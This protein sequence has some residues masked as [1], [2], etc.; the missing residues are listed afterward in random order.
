MKKYNVKVSEKAGDSDVQRRYYADNNSILPYAIIEMNAISNGVQT[1]TNYEFIRRSSDTIRKTGL[2]SGCSTEFPFKKPDNSVILSI[3]IEENTD[4]HI[5]R[6]AVNIGLAVMTYGA[7]LLLTK[8][9]DSFSQSV[10]LNVSRFDGATKQYF[11][12][13]GGDVEKSLF[14]DHSKA[15]TD[16]IWQ[17]INANLCSIC[18]QMVDDS[19]FFI[20]KT[21]DTQLVSPNEL[22]FDNQASKKYCST[23]GKQL[24]ANVAFCSTCGAKVI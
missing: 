8:K 20:V 2:F 18:N 7:S 4:Q 23:C 6:T 9:K 21:S 17:M 1:S 10:S 22:R 16:L 15:N 11:A 12:K 5:G 19:E 13:S 14:A 24:E 3:T